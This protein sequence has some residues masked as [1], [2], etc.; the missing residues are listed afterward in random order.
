[1]TLLDQIGQTPLV[2]LQKL[3]PK[4]EVTIWA[5]CEFLNPT[6]SIK[7]RIVKH[8]VTQAEQCGKIEPGYTL[9]E[10][11]SGNTGAAVAMIAAIKG[12]KAILVISDKV[13]KE[14]Q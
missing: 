11:T 10:S 8:I 3:S 9:I 2:K 12:Y 4:S 5:K 6:G 1:M 13:S 7:D 14:K